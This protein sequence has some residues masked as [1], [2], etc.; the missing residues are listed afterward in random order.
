MRGEGEPSES[1]T[2]RAQ[3]PET[4]YHQRSLH[5][6]RIELRAVGEPEKGVRKWSRAVSDQKVSSTVLQ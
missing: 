1:D 3:R 6:P 4:Q 5:E 2:C